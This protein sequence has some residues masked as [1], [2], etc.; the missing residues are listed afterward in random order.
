MVWFIWSPWLH[1]EDCCLTLVFKH[2]R[3]DSETFS[4]FVSY[5]FEKWKKWPQLNSMWVSWF[6]KI[7]TQNESC[8]TCAIHMIHTQ[9]IRLKEQ[10]LR[11]SDLSMWRPSLCAW[12]RLILQ[13]RWKAIHEKYFN[14]PDI[15]KSDSCCL[16]INLPTSI[17]QCLVLI[18]GAVRGE[19]NHL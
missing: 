12:T 8:C 2:L 5:H 17:E 3:K 1:V 10:L 6:K 15:S 14:S 19:C 11:E 16:H 4:V 13:S 9:S 7:T 18:G